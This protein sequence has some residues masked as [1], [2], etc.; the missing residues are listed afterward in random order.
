MY[1]V[2]LSV[3]ACPLAIGGGIYNPRDVVLTRTPLFT[4]SIV[5]CCHTAIVCC[6]TRDPQVVRIYGMDGWLNREEASV[7]RMPNFV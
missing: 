1:E 6:E 5:H 7:A 3:I 4:S 2:H